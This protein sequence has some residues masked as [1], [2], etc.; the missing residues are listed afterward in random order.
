MPESSTGDEAL[1]GSAAE[2]VK[3]L[4]GDA[5]NSSA[6][7]EGAP[8]A[9]SPAAEKQDDKKP[10]D[11]ADAVRAALSKGEEQSSG[12]GE[13]EEEETDPSK[14]LAE[15]EK[16][17]EG[18]EDDL[19]DLTEEELK[20]YKPK[21]RRRFE[22]LDRENK[23]FTAEISQLK[24]QAE[25]FQAIETYA[26]NANLNKD[27]INTGF[28]IMRL[29]KN[30]PVKAWD[31][32]QPIVQ[33]LQ[34]LVGEILPKD[35]QAQVDAGQI[36]IERAKE[37]SRLRA[38]KGV[39]TSTTAQ[40]AE[41][42]KEN[43][44]AEAKR[45]SD[46]LVAT[47]STAISKWESDWKASDPDY[48]LKQSRVSEA[49]ELELSRATALAREGKANNLPRNVEEAVKMANEVKKRVEKEMRAYIPKRNQPINHITG[50]GVTNGSKPAARN[51]QEVVRLA[52]GHK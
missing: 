21:T 11:I 35:L 46:N 51:M 3:N 34:A 23:A 26:R 40:Q 49:I 16:P 31:V 27:D 9:D 29:M 14:P 7:T 17:K 32:L 4:P 36:P 37:L 33:A 47:V 5:G 25:K 18:E 52:V 1:H 6:D 48:S 42:D 39:T 45:N 13:G 20:S 19:G 2:E 44:A 28:E 43:R 30:D 24:P 38:E 12:S 8:P 15:G 22:K 50:N 10:L 41:R